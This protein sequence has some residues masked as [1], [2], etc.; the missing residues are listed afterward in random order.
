M[1]DTPIENQEVESLRSESSGCY[2]ES[3]GVQCR[4][5]GGNGHRDFVRVKGRAG[6]AG[7]LAVHSSLLLPVVVGATGRALSFRG[8]HLLVPTCFDQYSY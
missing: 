4:S 2:P 8:R 6:A 3:S 1:N 5:G 7:A